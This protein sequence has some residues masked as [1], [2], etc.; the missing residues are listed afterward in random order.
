M[1]S[2]A[3]L[4]SQFGIWDLGFWIEDHV[5]ALLLFCPNTFECPDDLAASGLTAT[6]TEIATVARFLA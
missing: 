6:Q 1:L 5:E 2:T 3:V 4:I